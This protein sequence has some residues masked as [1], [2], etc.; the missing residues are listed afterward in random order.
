VTD[1]GQTPGVE[2]G[3]DATAASSSLKMM[4]RATY[5]R[6]ALLKN[7]FLV[8]AV[9]AVAAV[10]LIFVFTLARGW[11][12]VKDPGL[13]AF[14]GGTEWSATLGRFGIMPLVVGTLAITTGSLVLGAPSPSVLRSSSRRS[15]RRGSGRSYVPLSRC[16]PV[17][18][19]W[20]TAS[21][22]S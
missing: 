13:A 22:G 19:R 12:V 9:V 14:L 4:S 3:R 1:T 11:G 18:P 8:C 17:C 16:W 21:S 15:H 5:L 2:S 7:L 20:C 10:A 6:E